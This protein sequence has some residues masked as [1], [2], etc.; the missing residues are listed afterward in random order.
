MDK[1][2]CWIV[3]HVERLS[4]SGK[5]KL[6]RVGQNEKKSNETIIKILTSRVIFVMRNVTSGLRQTYSMSRG[7]RIRFV[8]V[9][10][11]K[12]SID[13]CSNE[14][15]VRSLCCHVNLYNRLNSKRNRSFFSREE[16][17]H[18]ERCAFMIWYLVFTK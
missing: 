12:D 18:L 7:P 3:R 5:D 9:V 11:K 4:R 6:P 15:I 13:V 1:G 16:R 10:V 14:G 8:R 2:Q 17:S